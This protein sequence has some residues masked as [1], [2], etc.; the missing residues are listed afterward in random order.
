ML[1]VHPI[2]E[3][4]APEIVMVLGA[5]LVLL[6][7]LS[8]TMGARSALVSLV[9]IGVALWFAA[10]IRDAE[11]DAEA[12]PS[13]QYG[14]LVWYARLMTLAI[15]ALIVLVNH[16]VPEESESGEYFA[17]ILFSLAG[18]PLAAAANSL[19]VLFL[20]LELVSVPTYILI[21][22]FR[23][24]IH[25]QESAGKYFFLG[26]FAAAITLY[27]FSF[28][29]GFG[30][31][32][33]MFGE[34]SIAE[35]LS[36]TASLRDPLALTGLLLS[37]AGLSF[38]IAAVPF[39]F[40]VGDVYQGAASPVTGLLGFV[41]KFAGFLAVL[42]VLSLTG[43]QISAGIF[44]LLWILAA[45]TMTIGN[46]LALMQYNVKRMLAYSGVA[47]T[48]YML[49]ALLAGPATI[50]IVGA[51]LRDG[52]AALLFY[53][54]A[55]GVM[56]LG[57]FAALSYLRKPGEDDLD[58]SAETIDD[59]AG[60]AREHPW[61]TLA[62][63]LCVL[64]LMGFPLTAGFMG[65]LYIISAAVSAS[66]GL[67]E[68]SGPMLALVV[69][70]ALNA[71]VAAAYYLRI[72]A[73]CYLRKPA[74]GVVS[75]TCPALRLSLA[76]CALLAILIFFRPGILYQESRRAVAGLADRASEVE[77]IAT[78]PDEQDTAP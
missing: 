5:T 2:I 59:I 42:Q 46:T 16:H 4:L 35:K 64:G 32:M 47:H 7:G 9:T 38:K 67:A 61:A 49:V 53:M 27:G 77:M 58:E 8:R 62:L 17:L 21:G 12:I 25:A 13:L 50:S 29:Y 3:L 22:L 24:D 23:R 20:A 45:V 60:A 54:T 63:S 31:T 41:P 15:G 19:I 69:I 70:L 51:P 40:Y 26:A 14:P 73:A 71:A 55:Y 65:K 72:L 37:L 18:I 10:N 44:W 33:T 6:C 11:F 1:A 75:S 66:A 36:V 30:G 43:W 48:G 57:C 34:H 68:R 78:G 39:H 74:A 76:I 28:L 56:N 52:L